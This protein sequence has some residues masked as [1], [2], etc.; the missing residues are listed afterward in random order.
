L[1][2]PKTKRW[3]SFQRLSLHL[4]RIFLGAGG[5]D[6]AEETFQNPEILNRGSL[7]HEAVLLLK[8]SFSRWSAPVRERLLEWM[9]RGWSEDAIRRWLEFSGQPVTEDSIQRIGDI[10]KRDH[11]AILQGQLPEPY[12]QK[13]DELVA[14]VGPAR[15][16]G[17]PRGIS[18]GAFGAV[19]PKAPEEF[20]A[21]SVAEI[22]EFL[23]TWTPGTDIF[24]A[25]AEGAGRDLGAAVIA[26]LDDFVAAAGDFKH[27]DPTYVHH[28]EP[29]PCI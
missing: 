7:Q 8:A 17:E 12:Q 22:V 29:E 25:T 28:L 26:K 3:T 20:S 14:K 15:E 6:I 16:L 9:G 1:D 11:L 24:A 19:S 23:A 18:G 2:V 27:L 13:L 21:M 5:S 4:C 10:W